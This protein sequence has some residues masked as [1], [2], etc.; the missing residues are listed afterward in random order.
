MDLTTL[1]Y[2]AGATGFFSSR[3]FIPAFFTAAFIRY[4]HLVPFAGLED[5]PFI[6]VTGGEPTWFTS[7]ITLLVLGVL[8]AMEVAATKVPEAQELLDEVHKYSKT[9][10]AG[11][12][13]MGVL[14]TKDTAFIEGTM[15]QAGVIDVTLSGLVA[16]AVWMLSTLRGGAMELLSDADPD[17]DFGI[18]SLIGWFEDLW[19]SFGVYLLIL[20]PLFILTI[21]G[22]IVGTIFGLRKMAERREDKAKQPCP[23]CGTPVYGCAPECPSCH[24]QMASPKDVGFLGT[25]IERPAAPPEQHA[26]RLLSKRRC[27]KCAERIQQR[28]L[29][30]PCSACAHEVLGDPAAQSAYFARVR[31]RLPK[32]LGVTFLLSLIPVLGIIPGI[33]YYRVQLVAPFRLYIPASRGIALK[34]L[35]R[36]IFLGLISLQLIPGLGGLMVP[37]MAL[38]S[39]SLY[40]GY[41]N[42][43]LGKS[44]PATA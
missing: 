35:V 14:S 42:R 30:V 6:Q 24:Q 13:T 22:A 25:T 43:M 29:P 11:L 21:L 8:A 12:A 27:P 5:Q 18:R 23:S 2:L 39:Y 20:Y 38:I 26:F 31:G 17:D 7:N 41:F 33:I 9:A 36:L 3:A 40:A 44:V 4:G 34:W 32:V 28:R 1:L 37:A 19:A 10:M 16:G 15:Q